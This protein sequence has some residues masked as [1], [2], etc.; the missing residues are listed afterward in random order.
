MKILLAAINAKYIHSNLAVH[1]L[2][3]YAQSSYMP[4]EGAFR[5]RQ[6][7]RNIR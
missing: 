7:S 2:A 5:L 6:I 1:S 4:R 3:A